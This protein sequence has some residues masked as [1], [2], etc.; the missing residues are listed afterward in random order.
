MEL[1]SI[2]G[3]PERSEAG[4]RWILFENPEQGDEPAGYVFEKNG[5]I[6]SIICSYR[7]M[8]RNRQAERSQVM[9]HTFVSGL[10][11]PGSGFR[12]VKHFLAKHG[13]DVANT[14]NNNALSAPIYP[15]VGAIAWR[16]DDGRNFIERPLKWSSLVRS[17]VY[18]G[19]SGGPLRALVTGWEH[20][21]RGVRGLPTDG[22]FAAFTVL[23]PNAPSCAAQLDA[24]NDAMRS[25]D[26][27]QA[28]RSAKIWSY[29]LRDPDYKNG[30]C[31]LGALDGDR[32]IALLSV[33]LAKDDE[34][35]A[36]A[37]EIEDMV[38]LD[39]GMV[40]QKDMLAA[41]CAIGSKSGAARVRHRMP[42]AELLSELPEG[43][44]LRSRSYDNAHIKSRVEDV[45]ELWQAG[46]FDS[47]FFFA[48][49]RPEKLRG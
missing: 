25:G 42:S 49:R 40:S 38:S 44:M 12:L 11:S 20:L 27:F 46:P 1:V 24:F 41:A 2:C 34:F 14:L 39:H 17:R 31:V 45:P 9:A 8:Y 19:L 6:D 23:D 29:R 3:F 7:R 10:E 22:Q 15:R 33:S 48:L 37:L 35:S 21:E 13:A 30:M 32:L 4:W 16:G 47:D 28:D 36:S 26:Q 18:N 43:W 5:R